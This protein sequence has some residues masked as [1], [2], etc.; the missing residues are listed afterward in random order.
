MEEVEAVVA[1]VIRSPLEVELLR[2]FLLEKLNAEIHS[3]INGCA[4]Y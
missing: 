3:F 4:M 1:A 2:L